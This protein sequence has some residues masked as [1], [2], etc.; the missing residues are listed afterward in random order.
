MKKTFRTVTGEE[1]ENL[2]AKLLPK[3]LKHRILLLSGHLGSGKTTFVKGLAKAL[4]IKK[5]IKSPTYIYVNRYFI[6][7]LPA[8]SLQLPAALCHIDLYRLPAKT[9]ARI[10]AELGLDELL[11]APNTFSCI[12]W[13][14]RMK[15]FP[16]KSS[17]IRFTKREKFH[18]IKVVL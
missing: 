5:R 4:G 7:N 15:H 9:D 14:E 3:L 6:P 12:E 18:E 17:K 10:F 1:T 8:S 11:G 16:F 13:P 2:A